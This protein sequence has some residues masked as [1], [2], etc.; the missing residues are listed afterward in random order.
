MS[1]NKIKPFFKIFLVLVLLT[2]AYVYHKQIIRYGYKAW[3][4]QKRYFSKPTTLRQQ[5]EFP[6][7]YTVHGID[8]SR[9]Q[10]EVNWKRLKARTLDDDT[11][12]FEF[13]FIKA[14]EGIFIEDPMFRD[15]WDDAKKNKIIRGAY[16]Y[17]LCNYDPKLQAKNFISSVKLQKGD[18]PPVIDIEET[19]GKS[20]KEIVRRLK[21]FILEIEKII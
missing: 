13:A 2:S 6:Q 5:I 1:K 3:R 21:I 12:T 9:W 14:T 10:D 8:V 18:F 20:K 4:F 15:N 17:F 16:H 11:I 7:G 19:A